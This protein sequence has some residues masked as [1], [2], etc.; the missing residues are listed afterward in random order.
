MKYR[1]DKLKL[2][3]ALNMTKIKKTEKEIN[4]LYSYCNRESK[5]VLNQIDIDI[6]NFTYL[7][8]AQVLIRGPTGRRKHTS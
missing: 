8:T 3:S 6:S 7:Q 4:T 1:K 2:R 5:Y